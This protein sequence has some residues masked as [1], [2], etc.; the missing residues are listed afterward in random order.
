MHPCTG[1]LRPPALKA[2]APRVRQA[3]ANPFGYDKKSEAAARA[4]LR[5]GNR[6]TVTESAPT[7]RPFRDS[8]PARAAR[9][10][11]IAPI[12]IAIATNCVPDA[13][14]TGALAA[15]AHESFASSG[16]AS[17]AAAN[18]TISH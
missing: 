12:L 3:R 9:V 4:D 13:E 8:T 6:N 10:R 7:S 5:A 16:N 15:L 11:P 18:Q 1:S 17:R 14:N 2:L